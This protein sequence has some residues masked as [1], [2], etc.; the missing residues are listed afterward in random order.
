[1][2][3]IFKQELKLTDEQTITIPEKS[4]F[5]SCKEQDGKL[6]LWYLCQ[7]E[8]QITDVKIRIIGTG[9]EIDDDFFDINDVFY[10]D[11]VIMKNGFVWHIFIV[12]EEE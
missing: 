4:L 1:M 9:N 3:R 12:G 10:L 7:L 2:K 8:S 6:C 5:L 11:T